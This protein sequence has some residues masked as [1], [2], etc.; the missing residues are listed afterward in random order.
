MNWL[1]NYTGKSYWFKMLI[2]IG[3][4]SIIVVILSSAVLFYKSR[5]TMLNMQHESN[6]KMLEQVSYNLSFTDRMLT[7]LITSTYMDLRTAYLLDS[8]Q[9]EEFKLYSSIMS[10]EKLQS[11]VPLLHS[12]AVY[13]SRNGC[14]YYYSETKVLNCRDD[15]MDG[16]VDRYLMKADHVPKLQL[17]PIY[18]SDSDRRISHFSFFMYNSSSGNL[19]GT[20]NGALIFN[21]KPEWLFSNVSE[22]NRLTEY[23]DSHLLIIDGSGNIV[24]DLSGNGSWDRLRDRVETRRLN[25]GGTHSFI[26]DSDGIASLVTYVSA[27]QNNWTL[28]SVQPYDA[29]FR[30]IQEMKAFTLF[31]VA[32]ILL[33]VAVSSTLLASRLYNPVSGVLRLIR[34]D[35]D[36]HE[37]AG[38]ARRDEFGVISTVLE[39]TM[40]EMRSLKQMQDSQSGILRGYYVRQLLMDNPHVSPFDAAD[41]LYAGS[42]HGQR[43][44]SIC[45]LMLDDYAAFLYSHSPEDRRLYT[46]SIVNI[47]QEMISRSMHGDVVEV[48][49]DRFVAL[50]YD[51]N[52]GQ[53]EPQLAERIHRFAAEVQQTIMTY[54][55]L[56]LTAVFGDPAP[57][58]AQIARL[59]R[60]VDNYAKYRFVHGKQ[61]VIHP[62][63]VRQSEENQTESAAIELEKSWLLSIRTRNEEESAR[64]LQELFSLIAKFRYEEM[65]NTLLSLAAG[66]AHELRMAKG[67]GGAPDLRSV[68]KLILEKETIEDVRGLFAQLFHLSS[69]DGIDAASSETTK[70]Q[71][72]VATIRDIVESRYTDSALCLQSIADMVH[73]SSSYVGKQFRDE[74]GLSVA[75]YITQVRMNHAADL[76]SQSEASV[77]TVMERVGFVNQSYFF[78][79]FKQHF[80]LTPNEYK[81]Q[82]AGKHE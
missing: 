64:L 68:Y 1:R 9:P 70:R 48:G 65:I 21:I 79:L 41:K 77:N 73:L 74:T 52:S 50:L 71:L 69:E 81:I 63:L 16:R 60:T 14:Y 6:R 40:N 7:N 54:Y 2:S 67:E 43:R 32:V 49:G 20:D 51:D 33:L 55:K 28:V 15:G 18:Y 31:A 44:Y 26:D 25:D 42:G 17:V 29:V 23:S 8:A 3:L 75:K 5:N 80:G 46:F 58:Y 4:L 56:S 72:L 10:F 76:L 45:L 57:D 36:L 12:V 24:N 11:S 39:K 27:P 38:S 47:V 22:M 53:S 35:P 66:A 78:K 19:I 34:K 37:P 62:A 13:N 61:S 30:V 82:Y 59:Y